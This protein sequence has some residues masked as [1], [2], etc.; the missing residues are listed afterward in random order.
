MSS[1]G[2]TCPHAL[3]QS[4][5]RVAMQDMEVLVGSLHDGCNG[6][7]F[8]CEQGGEDDNVVMRNLREEL[9]ATSSEEH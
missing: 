1:A 3:A 7:D 8:V 4:Q 2:S 5:L 6:E 9:D